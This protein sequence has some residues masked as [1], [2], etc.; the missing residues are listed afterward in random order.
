MD[1]LTGDG[2][3]RPVAFAAD[4]AGFALKECL[5]QRLRTDGVPVVDLGTRSADPVDYPDVADGLVRALLRGEARRGVAVC[6]TGLGI[7][8][9]ANR[10]PGIRCAPSHDPDT[11]RLARAHNNA[12]VLA[13]G[14]RFV[15]PDTAW[16][17]LQMFLSTPFE[18]GRHADRVR[19]LG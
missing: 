8:M 3:R 6:G 1:P 14:A 11:V 18:A 9:A 16:T 15:D 2:D 7:S 19:K 17:C 4:H 5:L 12:N 10:H 13:L